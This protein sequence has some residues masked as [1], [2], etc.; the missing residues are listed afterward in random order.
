MQDMQERM[1]YLL[2]NYIS[3]KLKQHSVAKEEIKD[4][5][6]TAGKDLSDTNFGIVKI[7]ST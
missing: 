7:I 2:D 5:L 1:I 6:D 4:I 3:E